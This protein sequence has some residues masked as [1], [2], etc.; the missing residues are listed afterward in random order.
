MNELRA[1]GRCGMWLT[2]IML[3]VVVSAAALGLLWR[4]RQVGDGHGLG[5]QVLATAATIMAAM[6]PWCAMAV[7]ARG[8]AGGRARAGAQGGSA[9]YAGATAHLGQRPSEVSHPVRQAGR[10]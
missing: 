10:R 8:S 9:K 6:V 7:A 2:M 3:A 1:L 5:W 4:L